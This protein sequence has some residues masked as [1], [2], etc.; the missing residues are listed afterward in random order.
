MPNVSDVGDRATKRIRWIAR[1]WGAVLVAFTLVILI[2]YTWNWV[3]TGEADPYAV[4]DYPPIENLPPLLGG[5]RRSD[6]HCLQSG[7]PPGASDSL[8]DRS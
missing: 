3:T 7:R 2:D 1:I 5:N 4:E 6:C 8:A